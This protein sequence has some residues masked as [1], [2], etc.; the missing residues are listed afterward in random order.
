M[1]CVSS[2]RP[3]R[4]DLV[5]IK[6]LILEGEVVILSGSW[7]LE[8]TQYPG[9]CLAVLPGT[10]LFLS[11]DYMLDDHTNLGMLLYFK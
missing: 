4:Q 1:L 3:G 11:Q 10:H 6:T 8:S 2:T 9:I 5:L 7:F